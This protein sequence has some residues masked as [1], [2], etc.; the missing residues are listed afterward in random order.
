M[1]LDEVSGNIQLVH[2]DFS[3]GVQW[4]L[5][6]RHLGWD[7][8]NRRVYTGQCKITDENNPRHNEHTFVAAVF[9]DDGKLLAIKHVDT[10][11]DAIDVAGTTIAHRQKGYGPDPR[12]HKRSWM[13]ITD[14][15]ADQ[16]GFDN[17]L[18]RHEDY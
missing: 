14:M 7:G 3:N 12:N 4:T 9:K 16:E 17:S 18:N 8:H 2:V 15:Q 10:L 6:L 5:W 13:T 11:E 1:K